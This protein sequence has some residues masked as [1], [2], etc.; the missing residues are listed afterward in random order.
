MAFMAK[1]ISSLSWGTTTGGM[2]TT[3]FMSTTRRPL[4]AYLRYANSKFTSP[5]KR[6]EGSPQRQGAL[7]S[8]SIKGVL[9]P[10]AHEQVG[11]RSNVSS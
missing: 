9:V 8:E 2:A 7:E 5:Q 6:H 10:E 4:G 11:D 1:R 3:S